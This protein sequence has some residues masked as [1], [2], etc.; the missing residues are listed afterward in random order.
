LSQEFAAPPRAREA[1]AVLALVGLLV[2]GYLTLYKL[3]YLG[4]IQCT[5][6]GCETVQSSQY[7]VFLGFPVAAWGVA[8]Y[9][10]LL[11]LAIAGLQPGRVADRRIALGIF[12]ISAVGVGFS[13]WL[14]YLE[15]MVINAW[16][17]WCV[18]SAI[19]ILLIF[20]MSIPGLR[21]TA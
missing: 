21:H 3:G 19:L 5:T 10:A 18:V 7:S 17:Q 15:A 4:V 11:V 2:S 12:A 20:L 8:A 16:C 1:I 14:A 13:G 6:G 9:A